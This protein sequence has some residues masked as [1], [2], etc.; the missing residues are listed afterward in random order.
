MTSRQDLL[1]AQAFR[2]R[3]LHAALVAGS[4]G[5]AGAEAPRPL[6]LLVGGLLVALLVVA[7]VAGRELLG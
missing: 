4:A 2:R 1:E 6:R 5:A 7:G 3:R